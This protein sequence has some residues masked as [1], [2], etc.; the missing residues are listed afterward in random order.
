MGFS[1]QEQIN[2]TGRSGPSIIKSSNGRSVTTKIDLTTFYAGLDERARRIHAAARP[3]AQAGVQVIYDQARINVPM[4]KKGHWF[5]GSQFK[6]TGKKYYFTP[7]SLKSA[8][9]QVFS[10]KKSSATVKTYHVSWNREK[11]P[12]AWMVEFGTSR[13]PAHP[14]LMPAIVNR[15]QDAIKAMKTRFLQELRT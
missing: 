12:Y 4:S 14:F 1:V 3:A 7:G 2:R 15:R 13:A 11:A 9:Y 8:I 10:E 5:H 6:K